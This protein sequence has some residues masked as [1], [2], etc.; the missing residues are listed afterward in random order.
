[1]IETCD[2]LEDALGLVKGYALGKGLCPQEAQ[3]LAEQVR[4]DAERAED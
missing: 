3:A 4:H 1:M 2:S